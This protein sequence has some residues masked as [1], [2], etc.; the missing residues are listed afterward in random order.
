MYTD[1]K[2]AAAQINRQVF[3]TAD[4]LYYEVRTPS[5]PEGIQ[6]YLGCN[7]IDNFIY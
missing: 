6:A 1:M 3:D 7:L 5:R 4:R 2:K